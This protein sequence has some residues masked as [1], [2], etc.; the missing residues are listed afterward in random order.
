[1]TQ[2]KIDFENPLFK[3]LLARNFKI[4]EKSLKY[5]VLPLVGDSITLGNVIYRIAYVRAN[6]FR[7]SAEPIGILTDEDFE[8]ELKKAVENP[9]KKDDVLLSPIDANP[10]VPS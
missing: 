10:V 2:K 4:D 9:A 1:M 6:P 8:K 7:F 5:F 3:T